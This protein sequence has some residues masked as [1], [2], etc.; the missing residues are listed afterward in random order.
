MW[1]QQEALPSRRCFQWQSEDSH[2]RSNWFLLPILSTSAV[3]RFFFFQNL[4]SA[5]ASSHFSPAAEASA[6]FCTPEM[7]TCWGHHSSWGLRRPNINMDRTTSVKKNIILFILLPFVLAK[8]F[9]FWELQTSCMA[10]SIS[11]WLGLNSPSMY[12]CNSVDSY[13]FLFWGTITSG[14]DSVSGSSPV[15]SSFSLSKKMKY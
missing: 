13:S 8:T 11:S 12:S 10:C 4:A 5:L 15:C 2:W 6:S 7:Q 14:I 1:I 3:A 9:D